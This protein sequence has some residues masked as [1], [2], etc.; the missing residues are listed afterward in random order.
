MIN[1]EYYNFWEEYKPLNIS[2]I[3]LSEVKI[4][5]HEIDSCHFMRRNACCI[6]DK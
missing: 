2:F 5:F 4:I 3:T 6:H 1:K